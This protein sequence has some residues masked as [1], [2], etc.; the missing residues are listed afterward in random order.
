MG[1]GLNGH[2][3]AR[4][5]TGDTP[6]L[7]VTT[8]EWEFPV[9]GGLTGK[10]CEWVM[11]RI[12]SGREGPLRLFAGRGA[13]LTYSRWKIQFLIR[14]IRARLHAG[15]KLSEAAGNVWEWGRLVAAKYYRNG[16]RQNPNGRQRPLAS[17]RA[18]TEGMTDCSR[19]SSLLVDAL[20]RERVALQALAGTHSCLPLS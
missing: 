6:P 12:R 13:T 7:A 14:S 16:A 19:I 15:F 1:I 9:R 18:G 5:E 2:L 20:E 3:A 8:A 10:R 11:K 4:A 17:C